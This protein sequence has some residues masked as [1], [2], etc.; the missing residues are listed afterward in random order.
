MVRVHATD[1]CL[2]ENLSS[3]CVCNARPK[4]ISITVHS[5]CYHTCYIW[6]SKST[7]YHANYSN[8][9][10][11]HESILLVALFILPTPL[12]GYYFS[13]IWNAPI[14]VFPSCRYRLTENP[15]LLYRLA[16]LG[17][18]G[19][20]PSRSDFFTY[21]ES[22]P[23]FST[24][25]RSGDLVNQLLTSHPYVSPALFIGYPFFSD[26]IRS[27][28]NYLWVVFVIRWHAQI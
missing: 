9:A 25:T 1:T 2:P 8:S 26:Y 28:I 19:S 17:V 11:A 23:S 6:I 21:P 14:F 3:G 13:P 27:F 16:A 15:A 12:L 22:P 24:N 10:R 4:V 20:S 18:E 7:W 5:F